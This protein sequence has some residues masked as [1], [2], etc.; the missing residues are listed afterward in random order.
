MGT[1]AGI[2]GYTTGENS[3]SRD[4]SGQVWK[5]AGL[6]VAIG[7]V[8]GRFMGERW[9]EGMGGSGRGGLNPEYINYK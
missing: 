5:R 2:S 8:Q 6:L 4:K 1:G 7:G 3:V 9:R